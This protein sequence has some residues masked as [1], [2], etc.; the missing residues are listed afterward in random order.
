VPALCAIFDDLR[1]LVIRETEMGDDRE[2]LSAPIDDLIDALG[3]PLPKRRPAG[4]KA[5]PDGLPMLTPR[6]V[7]S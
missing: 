4:V 6:H 1:G 5:R 3:V 2:I 7:R